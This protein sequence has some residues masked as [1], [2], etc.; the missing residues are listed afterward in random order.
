MCRPRGLVLDD[1]ADAGALLHH[2]QAFVAELVEGDGA[3]GERMARRAREDDLVVEE[4]LEHDGAVTARGAD[5]AELELARGDPLDHRLR[6][7]HRQ[8]DPE[9][10]VLALELA[11]QERDD[12]RG[13]AR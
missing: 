4:R 1:L 9:R 3:A 10:R 13:G 5:D 11:E 12:D 8:G 2:D 6:V 7:R